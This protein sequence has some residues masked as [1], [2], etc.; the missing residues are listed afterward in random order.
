MMNQVHQALQTHLIQ[1]SGTQS[2]SPASSSSSNTS[3]TESG[4]QSDSPAPSEPEKAN[5]DAL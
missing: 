3:H 1:N 4:T 2:D 5:S